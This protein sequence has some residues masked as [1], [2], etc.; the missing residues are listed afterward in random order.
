MTFATKYCHRLLRKGGPEPWI[1]RCCRDPYTKQC[2]QTFFLLLANLKQQLRKA[3]TRGRCFA[4]ELL[5]TSHH[6]C[7]EWLVKLSPP[8]LHSR[9]TLPGSCRYCSSFSFDIDDAE[10]AG[11]EEAGT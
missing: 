10:G 7:T 4:N 3:I 1:W 8:A 6:W 9:H 11:I 2:L 5:S